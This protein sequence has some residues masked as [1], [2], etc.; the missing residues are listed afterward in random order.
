MPGEKTGEE[1]EVKSL[2]IN[3]ITYY[4]LDSRISSQDISNWRGKVGVTYSVVTSL[5]STGAVGTIYLVSNSGS[6]QNIYDEY[7]YVNNKFEKIGTTETD[8]TG[9]VT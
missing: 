7:I 1:N 6:G 9:F 3:G 2:T 5:P 4:L 8:L